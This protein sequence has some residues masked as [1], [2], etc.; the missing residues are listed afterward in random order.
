MAK[1]ID[2]HIHSNFSDGVLSPKQIVDEAKKNNVSV[3]AIADHDCIDAY[4]QDL[5]DYANK[6][7]INLVN[8]VEIST[9]WNGFGIHVLGYNFDLENK[10]LIETLNKLKNARKDYFVNV[11]KKLAEL[12]YFVDVEKLSNIQ[13]ITKAHISQEVVSNEKNRELLLKNFGHVPEKGEFIE[14]IM[15]EGCPA[16]VEK[17]SIS[18]IEASK[19]IHDAGGKVVL[20]HPVAYKHE[21]G[22][23]W[24]WILN[25]AKKMNADGIEANY[26][27]VNQYNE[28]IDETEFWNKL[29]KDN[30]FFVTTGSDFHDFDAIRPDIGFVNTSFVLDDGKAKHILKIL[31]NKNHQWWWF[32]IILL[33][34]Q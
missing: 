31:K 10:L 8:A 9:T 20:A 23:E 22:V 17:F 3:L 19:I 29:A 5:F 16:F 14:T 33:V 15:N 7:G 25:L 13:L 27:Y 28:L 6:E 2:L 1:F 4:S 34:Q 32:F 18:P 12:G 26:L 21:D 11:S 30:G 24:N